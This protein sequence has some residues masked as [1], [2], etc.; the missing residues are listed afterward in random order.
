V[1]DYQVKI[2]QDLLKV[3]KCKHKSCKLREYIIWEGL[4]GHLAVHL[5]VSNGDYHIRLCKAIGYHYSRV[6]DGQTD[7]R[8]DAHSGRAINM[9]LHRVLQ[10]IFNK[11]TL[12]LLSWRL[13]IRYGKNFLGIYPTVNGWKTHHSCFIVQFMHNKLSSK[14][15]ALFAVVRTTLQND[16]STCQLYLAYLQHYQLTLLMLADDSALLIL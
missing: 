12:W 2:R 14:F 3:S 13:L 10:T 6:R 8:T 16:L 11:P 1:N 4:R 9:P 7:G 15:W 5:L